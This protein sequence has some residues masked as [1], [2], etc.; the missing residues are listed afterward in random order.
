MKAMFLLE[1]V[2]D[3]LIEDFK[4]NIERLKKMRSHSQI[5]GSS[6]SCIKSKNDSGKKRVV[7][8][9]MPPGRLL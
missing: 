9:D 1:R 4:N 2:N 5:N 3:N 6:R 8:F 7:Y